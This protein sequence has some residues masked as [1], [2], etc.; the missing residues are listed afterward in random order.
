MNPATLIPAPDAIPVGW[1]WFQFL[2]TLTFYL[3]ILAMNIM[4][5]TVI[6][7]FFHHAVSEG[8]TS[9]LTGQIAGKLPYTIALT[10]NLGVAPLLFAQ[11]IYG[12]FIYVSSILMGVFWLSIVALLILGYYSAYI[13]MYKYQTMRLGR[14]VT[15]GMAMLSLLCIG[16]FLSN[17][18]TLML[19]PE[20]WQRFFDHPNG[21]LLNLGDP[22]LI[23]RYLHMVVSAIAVGGLAI[24]LWYT[25][26]KKKGTPDCDRW[27]RHG[28]NWFATA[29]IVNFGIGFWFFG[30]LPQNLINAH[31]LPGAAFS[32][33][34][35]AAIICAFVS[36]IQAQRDRV[37]PATWLTLVMILLMIFM[38]DILRSLY[39]NPWFKPATLPVEPAWS[40]FLVFLLSLVAGLILVGWMLKTTYLQ[41][42]AREVRS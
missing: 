11:V 39:L 16:F 38:R 31:T 29:T 30:M 32:L 13:Y 15:S 8:K 22:T 36:V 37:L 5:G 2:L 6:I 27:I 28:C 19:H 18:M 7:A 41:L 20:K 17:N 21:F 10:V 4:L 26:Q 25:Y 35:V 40:P 33:L 42:R 12:H 23:P 14:I 24:A 34:L 9:P 3:H 1:G